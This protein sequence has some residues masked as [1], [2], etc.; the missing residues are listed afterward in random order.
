MAIGGTDWNP[1]AYDRFRGHRL[2]PAM[3]LLAQVGA[4]PGGDI[5]DL[6]CGSGA[7]GPALRA[8]AAGRRLAGVDA[9]PAM[10]ATARDTRAYDDLIEA[11]IAGWEPASPPALIFSNATLQWL[12][13]HAALLPRLAGTLAPGGWLAVQMPRQ[14]DRPSHDLLRRIAAR[15]FPDRFGQGN[16]VPP[17]APAADYWTMLAPLG[18]VA[19]WETDYVQHLPTAA[20]GHPVRAFTGSTAM[21]PFLDRL[22]PDEAAAFIAAYDIALADAYPLRTDGSALFPFRRTFLTLRV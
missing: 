19:A 16:R 5:V 12:P 20:E 8:R 13:D 2:R 1:G 11:D 7:A 17:V 6:G 10:L 14:D 21:R 3:D 9:S 22:A 4:L 18:Q 15:M